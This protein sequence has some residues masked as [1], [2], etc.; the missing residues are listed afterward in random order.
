MRNLE[1]ALFHERV[2]S[3]DVLRI[4]IYDGLLRCERMLVDGLIYHQAT[5]VEAEHCPGPLIVAVLYLESKLLVEAT[6]VAIC[7]T[8]S[9]APE[10]VQS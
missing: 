3:H 2:I 5:L 10:A 8:G 7:R 4:Q 9:M 6:L 1:P